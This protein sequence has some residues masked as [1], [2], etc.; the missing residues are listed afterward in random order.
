MEAIATEVE[1]YEREL[2]KIQIEQSED[3]RAVDRQAKSMDRYLAKRQ[4]LTQRKDECNRSIRDLG[5]LPE[6]AFEKYVGIKSDKVSP[7]H[8]SLKPYLETL[9]VFFRFSF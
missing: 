1:T 7:S 8:T 3:G 2:E 5:V 4:M 6:E 9:T